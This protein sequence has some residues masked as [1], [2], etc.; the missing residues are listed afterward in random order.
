MDN[1]KT[2]SL[3]KLLRKEK[4]MTQK[5]LAEWLHVTDRAVSKWERG[6]C[7]PDIALLEPLS[8]ILGVSITELISGERALEGV[9]PGTE[10]KVTEAITASFRELTQKTGAYRRRVRL[11]AAALLAFAVLWG[12]SRYAPVIFQ[13]GNPVPYL[14]A[15][16]QIDTDNRYVK[17]DVPGSYGIYITLRGDSGRL[18]YDI[19]YDRGFEFVEQMG[20]G[21]VF[22]DG[23][24]RFT[25]SSEV[26]LR[27][28]TVWTVPTNTFAGQ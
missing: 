11:L 15:A 13:R 24:N 23:T 9:D 28:F 3:I 12:C 5:E 14:S 16:M 10:E 26:Y 19:A 4:A 21:Y 7:A 8:E 17:V 2:G 1:I 27:Y 25:I 20:S 22:S 18:F 6:I